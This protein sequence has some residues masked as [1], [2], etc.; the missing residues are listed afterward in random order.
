MSKLSARA[1]TMLSNPTVVAVNQG[2]S[3]RSVMRVGRNLSVKK[4]KYGQGK[5]AAMVK[6][7]LASGSRRHIP[8]RC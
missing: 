5:N 4:D 3:G 7:A 6:S 1:L 2:P 8:E